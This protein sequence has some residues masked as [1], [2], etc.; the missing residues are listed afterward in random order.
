MPKTFNIQLT[1]GNFISSENLAYDIHS[2]TF[3]GQSE[4]NK[5]I[6]SEYE[7]I[8]LLEK[9]KVKITDT[10]NKELNF[11]QVL[12]KISK[13]NKEFKNKYLVFK[14]LS[15]KG[16]ILKTGLKFGAD[17]RAYEKKDLKKISKS[18][19]EKS[20]AKYLVF[21]Q[22][23]KQKINWYDFCAKHRIAH[24]SGKLGLIAVTD[25]ENSITYYVVDWKKI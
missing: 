12:K 5:I 4:E 13:K 9:Q 23:E 3:L 24:S 18:I 22:N 25:S 20:H 14:D 15:D 21:I 7:A 8:Y 2:R 17:F 10:K 19:L 11:N 6:F 1:A 16:Y